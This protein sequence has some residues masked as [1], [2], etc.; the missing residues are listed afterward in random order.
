MEPVFLTLDEVPEIHR[1]QIKRYGGSAGVRDAAGLESAV[2]MPQATFDGEY[3][4]T[5]VPAMAAYLFQ[6]C[7]NHPFVDGNKRV[8]AN[9]AIAFLLMDGCE[10]TFD[11]DE[12]VDVV[13]RVATG[14]LTK[15]DLSGTFPIPLPASRVKSRQVE[16][17][18]PRGSSFANRALRNWE[19]PVPKPVKSRGNPP[20]RSARQFFQYLST[21][22]GMDLVH[23]VQIAVESLPLPRPTVESQRTST[24]RHRAGYSLAASRLT[25]IT[26]R[27]RFGA[28]L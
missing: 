6:L 14:K 20:L 11:E 19:P 27:P 26:D 25:V 3:L 17:G 22:V 5:I 24:D 1:Q 7:Q 10:P 2:A 28:T 16:Q 15:A 8:G 23:K 21:R 12:L 18:P 9:A 13:L 4:H